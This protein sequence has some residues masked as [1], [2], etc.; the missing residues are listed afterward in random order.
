[1]GSDFEDNVEMDSMAFIT[2]DSDSSVNFENG[3]NDAK[4]LG[5][6]HSC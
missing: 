5:L 1:M 4:K 6:K 2:D 3:N